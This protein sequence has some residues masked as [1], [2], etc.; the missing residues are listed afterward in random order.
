ML[1]RF[2]T[3]TRRIASMWCFAT[4]LTACVTFAQ[5]TPVTLDP[6]E[7]GLD[8]IQERARLEFEERDAYFGILDHVR[9]VDPVELRA[10]ADEF[11][12]KRWEADPMGAETFQEF[13]ILADMLRNPAEYRGQPVILR[14]H[15]IRTV[16]YESDNEFGLSP[17]SESWLVTP[18]SQSHPMTVIYTQANERLPIG[19]EMV[20]GA[21]VVGYFLKLKPYGARDQKT[22]LA[23]VILAHTVD[24]RPP[25][26]G[27]MSVST[28]MRILG[29]V[30]LLAV[31][32]GAY[33]L[34]TP[35]PRTSAALQDQLEA[36]GPPDFTNLD[37]AG[38]SS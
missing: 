16:R 2:Q 10:A 27:R 18:N 11:L 19:E 13:P 14:G 34:L 35:R 9:R 24:V 20:N 21:Q 12:R 32:Y 8:R 28:S 33:R 37:D 15:V 29:L 7:F 25:P 5:S 3:I 17:L 36:E 31:A 6:V 38:S 23:P 1:P 30:I 26:A 22:R 4:A